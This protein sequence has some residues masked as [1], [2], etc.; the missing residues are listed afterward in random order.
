MYQDQYVIKQAYRP[1]IYTLNMV[2]NFNNLQIDE[3]IE[4]LNN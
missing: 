1:I 2:K 3:K 4:I